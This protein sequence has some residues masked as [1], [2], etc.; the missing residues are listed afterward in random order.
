MLEA[1]SNDS[2]ATLT[3]ADEIVGSQR[4]SQ[5]TDDI[6]AFLQLLERRWELLWL[7]CPNVFQG[8]DFDVD[9]I[10]LFKKIYIVIK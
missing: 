8:F 3:I 10:K 6:P 4:R 1:I 9:Q 5:K 7:C 2:I